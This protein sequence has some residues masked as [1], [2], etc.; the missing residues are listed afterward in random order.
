MT[1]TRFTVFSRVFLFTV[2]LG[3]L[4]DFIAIIL[5]TDAIITIRTVIVVFIVSIVFAL[6]G[7]FLID[8]TT[9]VCKHENFPEPV[10]TRS[11]K[12]RKRRG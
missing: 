5:G 9:L 11:K 3:V 10:K 7:E 12:R 8:K 1:L 4:E 2:I 6:L